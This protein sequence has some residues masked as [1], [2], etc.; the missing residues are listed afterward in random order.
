MMPTGF[1]KSHVPSGMWFR[2]AA[3]NTSAPANAAAIFMDL[4]LMIYRLLPASVLASPMMKIAARYPQML[5]VKSPTETAKKFSQ[6]KIKASAKPVA[7]GSML[8]STALPAMIPRNSGVI[9][10]E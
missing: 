6:E 3:I 2:L 4:A 1:P 9:K 8:P 5:T 10:L 7:S